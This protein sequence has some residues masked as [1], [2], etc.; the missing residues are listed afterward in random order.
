M[1]LGGSL[2]GDPSHPRLP[3]ELVPA[4]AWGANL[5]GLLSR[6]QWDTLRRQVAMN[7]G[8]SC[9]IC[10]HQ[11][12]RH[13]VEC[14]EVWEYDDQSHVQRLVRLTALCPACHQAKHFGSTSLRGLARVALAH[15][16][17]V[18]H[19]SYQDAQDHVAHALE[20]W[21]R[22]SA[23]EWTLDLSALRGYGLEPPTAMPREH[24]PRTPSSH[25]GIFAAHVRTPVRS[26]GIPRTGLTPS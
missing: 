14:H 5:R 18:N 8:T 15:L 21:Q 24:R 12:S 16:A 1:A 25:I 4:T 11:G 9:E 19:W 22:R 26:T 20:V 7:A 23:H 3:V 2:V 17:R 6:A 10:G 13:A